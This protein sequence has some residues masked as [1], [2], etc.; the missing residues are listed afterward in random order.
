MK[1]NLNNVENVEETKEAVKGF[2]AYM[3]IYGEDEL[4][5]KVCG[6]FDGDAKK[7]SDRDIFEIKTFLL[8]KS[9]IPRSEIYH[10]VFE[11]LSDEDNRYL[12]DYYFEEEDDEEEK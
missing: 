2:N 8:I 6:M 4:I 10:T 1:E 9:G 5:A 11:I 3:E 7:L 12:I